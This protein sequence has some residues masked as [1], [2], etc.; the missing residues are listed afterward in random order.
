MRESSRKC[1]RPKPRLPS[2]HA[3]RTAAS[4]PAVPGALGANPQPNQVANS[5]AGFELFVFIGPG[6]AL[7]LGGL[8]NHVLV[9]GPVAKVDFPAALAAE[10]GF[11]VAQFYRSF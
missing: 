2:G 5:H 4:E 8:R 9:R 11:L 7:G 1:Q 3:I 6:L 10:R